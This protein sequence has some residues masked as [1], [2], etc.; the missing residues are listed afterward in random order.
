LFKIED[1]FEFESNGYDITDYNDADLARRPTMINGQPTLLPGTYRFQFRK[2]SVN[3]GSSANDYSQIYQ[4]IDAVS[5]ADNPASP[6]MDL[7][8]LGTVVDWEAWMR[9]FAV[10]RAVGNWDSYG[11][12][13]GKNDYLYR[14][15]TGYVHMPWDIDYSLGLGRPANEPLF[16]SNDPRIQAMFNT[17]AIVRAYWRAF[18]DLVN[19]PLSNA[20]LDPFIDAHTAALVGNDVN[21]D[22]N[23]VDA[24]KT[25]IGARQ[26]F[27]FSQL[28][29]VAA[30][31][32]VDGP[33]SFSTTNNLV[34]IT[35]TAPVGVKTMTLNGVT[36]PVTWTSATNFLL[37]VVV[38][39]SVNSLVLQGVDRLGNPLPDASSALT[40]EYTGPA[41][42]P[43]GALVISE[44]M[45]APATTGAQ[46][47]EIM[48][49]SAQNFDLWNW[50][51]VG[52]GLTFPAGS[53]ITNGQIVV[54]AQNRTAFLAAYGRQPLFAL[55]D[56]NLSAQGQ[57]LM[58]VRPGVLGDELIDGVHYE[59]GAPW[60]GITNGVSLQLIDT[61]QD[62]S[63]PS[64]W[65]AD[66]T[67]QATPGAPNSVATALTPYDPLW[68]NEIQIESLTGP[69][70]NLGE[71]E[72]WIELYNSGPTTLNLSG[73]YL[74]TSYTNDLTQFQFPAGTTI[75]PG[76][77]KLIWADGEPGET[78]D[79]N[80]HTSFRLDQSGQLALVRLVAGVPQ[81]TD[82]LTWQKVGVNL[83][84]GAF[85]DGQLLNRLTLYTPTAGGTNISPVLRVFINEWMAGN[86][87]GIR[88][89]VDGAQDDW[90]ELY[91]AEPFTVNLG[92]F[93]LSDDP[94]N[95]G[96]YR[97]PAN[98][99]Y[100][101][102]SG[103]FLL[104]WAD[105]QVNQNS[106]TNTH[107]HVN[108]KLGGSSG[109]IL[110][111]ASNS[112][113]FTL[114]DS[115]HYGQQTDNISE[116]RYP[117]GA[118]T[119]YFMPLVP[120][121]TPNAPNLTSS[122]NSPP[123]FPA[124][125]PLILQPGQSTGFITFRAT[126]PEGQIILTSGYT[127]DSPPPGAQYNIS[128]QFRWIVPTNQ[129]PGDYSFTVRVTDSGVPPSSG[130]ALITL[131]VVAPGTV[132]TITPP[133]VIESVF[134]V[135]GQATFTIETTPGRTYRVLYSDD[136]NSSTWIQLGRDFVAANPYAS[137]T[138]GSTARQRFYRV[139]QLD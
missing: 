59:A 77:F 74:T 61:A 22:L 75:A 91:N 48:N 66:R 42:D 136:L 117:D 28:E 14:T 47:I 95:P 65:A 32:V 41:A 132:T 120:Y 126:D 43:I 64:N 29:T 69:L 49:R 45:Y 9:H 53:I 44:I 101:I 85:P 111:T 122:Y 8:A 52:V 27:L 62:N 70:D 123:R 35:G 37:R 15:A 16:A 34:V 124:Y 18:A 83:S 105:N 11:W 127:F 112:L 76:E 107:L 135:A 129:P 138:D 24:I 55:F 102:P 20:T 10:Q 46:F 50:Q 137:F 58:L 89:P 68:L 13:R 100:Q 72:P 110:L 134:R 113:G 3:V 73:Y 99:R 90:F 51:L 60:P 38:N 19:G 23:A 118:S 94:G 108:F 86:S 30:P 131:I 56:A 21:I 87:L 39:S 7:D 88:D 109:D 26:A 103:G 114:I 40:I 93:Y 31:F 6:A 2:R 97:I 106:Q 80:V 121:S 5:P 139:Q 128:G 133:P 125:A 115:V 81:I 79:T 96:K 104:V 17:P 130:A 63:R 119:R 12:E 33:A 25:Y 84:Y 92:G 82:Y 1:W 78:S 71:S 4:L 36:Y 54:L 57:S 98:G 116:G 67:A